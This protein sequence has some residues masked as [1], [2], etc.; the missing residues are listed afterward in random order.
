[1][2]GTAVDDAE[3]RGAA[4]F[5]DF[6]TPSLGVNINININIIPF[7]SIF[8]MTGFEYYLSAGTQDFGEMGTGSE[9]EYEVSSLWAI[10]G[11]AGVKINIPFLEPPAN[12]FSSQKAPVGGPLARIRIGGGLQ[13]LSGAEVTVTGG[14]KDGTYT[15]WENYQIPITIFVAVGFEY[16]FSENFSFFAEGGWQHLG[17]PDIDGDM[18]T[19]AKNPSDLESEAISNIVILVGLTYGF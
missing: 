13:M 7:L 6:W 3:F 15:F 2:S 19:V 4:E 9:G 5:S 18:S 10:P 11:I 16:K 1:M 12:W 17:T 8:I 14:S